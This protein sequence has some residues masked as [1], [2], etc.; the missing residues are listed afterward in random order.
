MTSAI[1]LHRGKRRLGP[2]LTKLADLL[3]RSSDR[4]TR[5]YRHMNGAHLNGARQRISGGQYAGFGTQPAPSFAPPDESK[6][7]DEVLEA[8]TGPVIRDL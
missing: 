4:T 1:P 6:I 3:G 8:T 7:N 2:K 5:R